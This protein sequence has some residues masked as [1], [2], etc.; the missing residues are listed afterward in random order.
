MSAT[1][2]TSEAPAANRLSEFSMAGV[3]IRSVFRLC[4]ALGYDHIKM[5]AAVAVHAL[6]SYKFLTGIAPSTFVEC[7]A[8]SINQLEREIR[9]GG[10]DN[11]GVA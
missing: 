9:A 7:F 10:E 6:A 5:L 8:P 1:N 2:A 4:S 11:D 3:V